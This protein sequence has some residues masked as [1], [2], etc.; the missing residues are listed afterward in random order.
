MNYESPGNTSLEE[1]QPQDTDSSVHKYAEEINI[2]ERLSEDKLTEIGRDC[3]KGFDD[4]DQSRKEWLE[5]T[6]DWVD[7]A[8]QSK[9]QKNWP[10]PGASN[11]KYPLISTAAMQF[12]ARAYPTLI[13][14][15]GQ[16]V[17]SVVIGSDPTGEKTARGTKIEK[18][19][20]W[21]VMHDMEGWEEDMDRALIITPVV[22]MCFKK[23]FYDPIK[24]KNVSE[25][26]Y[27][28]NFV[29]DYY[30]KSIDTAERF[31]EIMAFT[32]RQIKEK[33]AQGV[34]LDI[35]L[36]T[37]P[38]P[39]P[40]PNKITNPPSTSDPTVPYKIIQQATWLDLDNDGIKEPYYVVFH[41]NSAKVLRIYA[42]F[43]VEGIKT[44]DKGDVISIEP[45]RQYTKIPFIPNPDGSFYDLG[46][47][48]LLGPINDAVNTTINQLIDAGTLATTQGGFIG[49]GLRIKAGET[50]IQPGEWKIVNAV[51][52][53][54]RKQIVPLPFKEPSNVLFELLGM[55]VQSGKELAS[56]AEI[57]VGKMP[58]QNTPATTTMA[59]IEQGMK[60]FTAIYKRIYRALNQEFKI[61]F[62][63]NAKYL[64]PQTAN[65]VLDEPI[66]PEDFDKNTYDICPAADPQ[67]SSQTERLTKAQALL[68]LV[69]LGTVDPIEVTKRILIAQDQPNWQKLIPGMAETGQPQIPPKQDPKIMEIQMKTKAEEQKA[70]I[71]LMESQQKMKLEEMTAKQKMAMEAQMHQQEMQQ[72]VQMAGID[73]QVAMQKAQTQAVTGAIT[74]ESQAQ[75]AQVKNQA[76]AATSQQKLKQ[77][78]EAHKQK[79]KQ[80]KETAKSKPKPAK[81]G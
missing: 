79:M 64:D 65:A 5:Q 78:D 15:D 19:M 59:S 30:I 81:S 60:V 16:V 69:Q 56:V 42:R 33:Q 2:A 7:M 75:Q 51:G 46:F 4:D 50:P 23:T 73:N 37:V 3:K 10:W 53:D 67:A 28:E 22:G 49:K 66:G 61:L 20:S 26:V 68:T 76:A 45:I 29:A 36:G 25:L 52:D 35:D 77:S 6:L 44:N 57:F 11:V 41:H 32:P 58:G 54:L 47:G 27:A 14:P 34:Y 24:E 38:T 39:T 70:Q 62:N 1:T 31:S 48:H 72:K 40:D 21:Q 18:Y 71:K 8:K 43:D 63:L 74:A 12:A 9:D 17:K 13:P 55:L 80:S